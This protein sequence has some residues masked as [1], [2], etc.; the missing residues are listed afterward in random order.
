MNRLFSNRGG[1]NYVANPYQEQISSSSEILIAAPY[2]TKTEQLVSAAQAGKKISLIVGINESTSPQALAA[3]MGLPNC[4]TPYFT[5]RFHAKIYVF[6]DA[7]LIGSSNLTDGG[8]Y[9][10]REA[11]LLV[12]DSEDLDEVRRL[13]LELW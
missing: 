9:S 8:L 12:E 4:A 13:F 11:T 6:D 5:T 10:N 3:L 1:A 7:A 2:V